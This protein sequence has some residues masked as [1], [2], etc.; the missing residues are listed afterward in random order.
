ME[1]EVEGE[2]VEELVLELDV[3]DED[4][5]GSQEA[6][7]KERAAAETQKTKKADYFLRFMFF[8]LNIGTDCII[9]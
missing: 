6:N 5:P 3:I 4:V 2:V 7:E 8:S 9:L 1:E